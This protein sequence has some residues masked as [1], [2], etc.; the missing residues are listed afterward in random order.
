VSE[1]GLIGSA[2]YTGVQKCFTNGKTR[3]NIRGI[4]EFTNT[5]NII[6]QTKMEKEEMEQ[7]TEFMLY[8]TGPKDLLD[9]WKARQEEIAALQREAEADP[10]AREERVAAMRNRRKPEAAE[11]YEVPAEDTEVIPVGEPKKKRRRDRN[12]AAE[13]R[14]QKPNTST[15]ENCRPQERLAVTHR[16]R[17]HRATVARKRQ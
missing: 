9:R 16:G 11:E 13:H 5:M 10:K 8:G 4:A 12:L 17:T 2:C 7:I 14:R 1:V 15:R 6:L 3:V